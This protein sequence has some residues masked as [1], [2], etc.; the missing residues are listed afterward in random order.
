[1]PAVARAPPM[2]VVTLMPSLSVRTPANT[3][4]RNVEPM[5]RDITIAAGKETRVEVVVTVVMAM[6]DA[7]FRGD[8]RNGG[9]TLE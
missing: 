3:E 7:R 6:S 1:M 4:K 9:K 2:N 8:D 5:E